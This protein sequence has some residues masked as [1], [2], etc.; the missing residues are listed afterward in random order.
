VDV[1]V[2][3]YWQA[4]GRTAFSE[5][6]FEKHFV[7]TTFAYKKRKVSVIIIEYNNNNL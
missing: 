3:K 4:Y 6:G 7:Y 1:Y 5:T 2:T